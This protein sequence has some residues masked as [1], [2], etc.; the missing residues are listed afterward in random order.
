MP[1]VYLHTSLLKYACTQVLMQANGATV[2]LNI[3]S[4][5]TQSGSTVTKSA[6]TGY[7]AGAHSTEQILSGAAGTSWRINYVPPL[8]Y[9]TRPCIW[10]MYT[11]TST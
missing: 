4:Q 3:V 5:I 10:C 7:N 11:A 2:V 6:T 9:G 1:D 8:I